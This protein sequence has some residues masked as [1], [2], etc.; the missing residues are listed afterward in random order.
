MRAKLRP[1][2]TP[3]EAASVVRTFE[4][5]E[6]GMSIY[7]GETLVVGTR[8][9]AEFSL[10]NGKGLLKINAIVR[11]RRG[12]RCGLEFVDMAEYER[13]EICR[14]LSTLADVIEI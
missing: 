6:G 8:L 2:E 13:T 11:N 5:S 7:A 14:Y 3:D 10:P 4:L 12:F 9:I 1:W